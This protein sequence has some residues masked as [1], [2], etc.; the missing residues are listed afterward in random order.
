LPTQTPEISRFIAAHFPVFP[1]RLL[2]LATY[3]DWARW[4]GIHFFC[5]SFGWYNLSEADFIFKHCFKITGD[6]GPLAWRDLGEDADGLVAAGEENFLWSGSVEILTR[7]RGGLASD[8]AFLGHLMARGGEHGISRIDPQQAVPMHMENWMKAEKQ[9]RKLMVRFN[10]NPC[11][12]QRLS[13]V[14]LKYSCL[15]LSPRRDVG[16][17]LL[18][19]V[20]C[21]SVC[22]KMLSSCPPRGPTSS[23]KNPSFMARKLANNR[24][25]NCINPTNDS[26]RDPILFSQYSR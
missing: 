5:V 13:S 1:D 7:Y 22:C 17:R 23:F 19:A 2:P 24:S 4:S 26:Q 9:Q 20:S 6:L 10:Q 25:Y 18:A 16:G 8:E 12:Y 21:S 11:T 15:F 3:C 14:F